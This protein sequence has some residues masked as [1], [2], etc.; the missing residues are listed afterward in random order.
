MMRNFAF[1]LVMAIATLAFGAPTPMPALA[2]QSECLTVDAMNA[3]LLD[4]RARRLAEIRRL[5]EGDIVK[6]DL[7][8]D[9][10]KLA[11]R[12]TLLTRDGLV[13]RVVLDASSGQFMTDQKK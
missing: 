5:L 7:C 10:G 12:V 3:A 13:K 2:Q 6:A 4:G 1:L 9:S 8:I 11:Y